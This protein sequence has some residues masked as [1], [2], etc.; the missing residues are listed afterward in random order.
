MEVKNESGS[1]IT[2]GSVVYLADKQGG[3]ATVS[4]TAPS[5]N[6]DA[7]IRLGV[8][9][10]QIADNSSGLIQWAPEFVAQI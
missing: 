7:V 8:A 5:S 4:A 1:A 3:A 6:D 10:A 9:A 2:A